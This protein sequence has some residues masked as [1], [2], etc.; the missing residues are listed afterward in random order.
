MSLFSSLHPQRPATTTSSVAPVAAV[1]RCTGAPTP[2]EMARAL[3]HHSRHDGSALRERWGSPMQFQ[4]ADTLPD[5]R[6]R[7]LLAFLM[8]QA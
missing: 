2:G 4:P 7:E 6:A 1:A 5:F 8:E 3:E